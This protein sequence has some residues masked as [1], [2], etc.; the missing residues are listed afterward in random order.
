MILGDS[1]ITKAAQAAS[2][3]AGAISGDGS[4]DAVKLVQR[5]DRLAVW[6]RNLSGPAIAFLLIGNVGLLTWGLK[7]GLWTAR[8]E[9]IRA[10]VVGVV[11]IVLAAILG[12]VAYVAHVGRPSRMEIAAGAASLK[13]E[14]GESE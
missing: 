12:L 14:Q 10:Q 9:I 7:I 11:A 13:I 1:S 3:V 4:P 2:T 8:S 5:D 6:M